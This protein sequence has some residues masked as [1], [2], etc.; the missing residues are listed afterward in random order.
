TARLWDLG[1]DV[2]RERAV[3]QGPAV[4]KFEVKSAPWLTEVLAQP[5]FSALYVCFSPDGKTLLTGRR[6]G[7]RLWDVSGPVPRE[8]P[9]PRDSLSPGRAYF[10]SVGQ[11]LAVPNEEDDI[12]LWDLDGAQPQERCVLGKSEQ[13]VAFSPDGREML[14]V[15][16]EQDKGTDRS[17]VAVKSWGLESGRLERQVGLEVDCGTWYGGFTP[18]ASDGQ[19][20]AAMTDVR[21]QRLSVWS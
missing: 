18:F 11:R 7:L 15:T 3:L 21:F 1:G 8:M 14:T 13:A 9:L 17:V 16:F 4:Q 19:T 10:S 20:V 5:Q 6:K 2:H 12:L